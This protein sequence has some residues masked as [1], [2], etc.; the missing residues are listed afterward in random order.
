MAFQIVEKNT[1][2]GFI[3]YNATEGRPRAKEALTLDTK[4]RFRINRALQERLGCVRKPIKLHVGFD[5]QTG[6]IGLARPGDIQTNTSPL[7]F[8]ADAGYASARG[9]LKQFNIKIDK[10]VRYI[11]TGEVEGGWMVFEPDNEACQ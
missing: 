7:S 2:T 5:P 8:G 6:R 9:F 4:E 3:P 11:F 1:K 10:T